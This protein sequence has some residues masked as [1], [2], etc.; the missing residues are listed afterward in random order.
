[1]VSLLLG[2]TAPPLALG[3]AIAAGLIVAETAVI[4]LLESVGVAHDGG[5][6]V[7][8]LLGVLVVATGW[9]L[10]L[11]VTMAVASAL[12]FVSFWN[13]PAVGNLLTQAQDWVV[14]A[15][16]LV[17]A[18]SAHTLA[19]LARTRAAEVDRRRQEAEESRDQ[20]EESR[21]QAE[22]SRDQLRVL[23]EQQAA[24]RRVATL[25]ARAATSCE[26]FPAVAEELA[27]CLGVHYAAL[28]RYQPDGTAILVAARDEPGVT[29]MPVGARFSLEGENVPAMVLRT[30][31]PARVDSYENA[32]GSTAARI[33]ELGLRGA[34]GA[35]VVVNGRVWGA[36]IVGSSRP[37]PLPPDTEA[38]V[39][40][41]AELVAT[42]I[43]N[44][45]AHAELT[46]SRVRIVAAADDARRRIERDLHDGA[47]QRLVSLGLELRSAQASVPPELDPLRGQISHIVSGLTGVSEDLQ[48]ISRGIH[49]AILS[50][51][52]GPALKTLARRSA[53]P[54][55]LDVH[56]D[57]R[58]PE[59]AEVAAYY[60]AAEALTNSAKHA[61]ASQVNARVEADRATLRLS[62]RDDGIG[63]ADTGR[64]SGIIG[65]IDRV[66]ALGGRMQ[67]ASRA[68]DGTSLLVTIPLEKPEGVD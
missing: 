11:A 50:K 57:R 39:A 29:K 14:I 62:I 33:R 28:W 49:P 65:L 48:E 10:G 51:G 46:A 67:I 21:D 43:A 41:F 38:R 8:Y 47:Q 13:W 42:A 54:V 30:G 40:D 34:V 58:L 7:V 68:G 17:V 63:G 55:E 37:Q 25:V 61:Q 36:A 64:G 22:E 66:E 12:A 15:I 23:A 4:Y 3:I 2:P 27:R 59:S 6:G 60:V 16:F 18:L 56:V 20:A 52:L 19:G 32:A 5:F 31:R 24:L 9:G 1:L 35:P 53:V 44:A 26:V 45:E